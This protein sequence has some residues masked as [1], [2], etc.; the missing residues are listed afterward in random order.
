MHLGQNN[1]SSFKITNKIKK[2]NLSYI[3][4]SLLLM[5][6]LKVNTINT[7]IKICGLQTL[8]G[9]TKELTQWG[10]VVNRITNH[11]IREGMS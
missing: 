8:D 11:C 4:F 5:M 7:F 1:Q 6:L 3:N 2:A 10:S 9:R